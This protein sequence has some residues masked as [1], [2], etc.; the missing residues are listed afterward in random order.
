MTF[1]FFYKSA[2]HGRSFFIFTFLIRLNQGPL[3]SEA[4]T[5]PTEPQPLPNKCH[6][7]TFVSLIGVLVHT[8]IQTFPVLLSNA[9]TILLNAPLCVGMFLIT[10]LRLS[11]YMLKIILLNNLSMG[12]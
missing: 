7:V 2:I 11:N 9:Q 3:V 1:S 8:P 4:P 12:L 5:L 6:E 10:K